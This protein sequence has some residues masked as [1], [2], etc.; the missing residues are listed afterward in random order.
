MR[1]PKSNMRDVPPNTSLRGLIDLMRMPIQRMVG[2]TML[3]TERLQGERGGSA[4]AGEVLTVQPKFGKWY[5]VT[6]KDG[7][8]LIGA[9]AS[10]LIPTPETCANLGIDVEPFSIWGAVPEGTIHRATAL[11]ETSDAFQGVRMSSG[12]SRFTPMDHL[13]K[14]QTM[15]VRRGKPTIMKWFAIEADAVKYRDTSCT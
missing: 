15:V 10:F 3:A 12:S 14:V 2:L 6:T 9:F 13:A 8:E 1:P 5:K 11:S 4:E 7:T